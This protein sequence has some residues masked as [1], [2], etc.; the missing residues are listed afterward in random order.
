MTQLAADLEVTTVSVRKAH[1]GHQQ[2]ESQLVQA[3]K[4]TALG[5]MVRLVSRIAADTNVQAD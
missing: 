2:P 3:E 5:Q 4:L 1:D